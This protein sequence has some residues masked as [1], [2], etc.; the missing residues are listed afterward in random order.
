MDTFSTKY[1]TYA[2]NLVKNSSFYEFCLSY[3]TME[4]N[5]FFIFYK[6]KCDLFFQVILKFQV[7][8]KKSR[9]NTET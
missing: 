4:L 9:V 5:F 3:I 1:H 6:I 7:N 2:F 8:Y